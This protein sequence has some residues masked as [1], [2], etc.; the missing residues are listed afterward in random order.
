[1]GLRTDRASFQEKFREANQT[2]AAGER[3]LQAFIWKQCCCFRSQSGRGMNATSHLSE[4]NTTDVTSI[5]KDAQCTIFDH[6]A[7]N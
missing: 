4:G 5:G 3:D 1:M 6:L 2:I 7:R